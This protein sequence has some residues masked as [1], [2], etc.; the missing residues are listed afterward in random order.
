M[1]S[2]VVLTGVTGIVGSR[3]GAALVERGHRLVALARPHLGRDAHARTV[4]AL[5][6]YLSAP[7]LS[8]VETLTVDVRE[9][10][11]GLHAN[12]FRRLAGHTEAFVHCA[13]D[14]RFDPRVADAIRA[15]NV[16]GTEHALHVARALGVELFAHVSTAFVSGDYSGLAPEIPHANFG[17]RFYNAYE[18]SKYD[19]ERAVTGAGVRWSIYRPPV[20]VGDSRTGEIHAFS[21]YYGLVREIQRLRA[22]LQLG[23]PLADALGQA[24]VHLR[25][26]GTMHLPVSVPGRTN[27][28]FT[29]ATVDF[30]CDATAD[31]LLRPESAF[32]TF[33]LVPPTSRTVGWWFYETFRYLGVDGF[34]IV[35][36]D[37]FET[38]RYESAIMRRMALGLRA[39]ERYLATP[40]SFAPTA[41]TR[42]A[43][44]ITHVPIDEALLAR[45]LDYAATRNFG[46]NE[47]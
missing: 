7:Q 18:Q 25:S 28:P 37:L 10:M 17:Q 16:G 31:L 38:P 22:A 36:P 6:R 26:D 13:A 41:L 29:A 11:C 9:P 33:H 43:P 35:E 39:Y 2:T 34:E 8:N 12:V 47:G 44:E 30:V 46:L 40:T 4:A 32:Q 24:G 42:I 19:A 20:V 15:T 27:A 5:S 23:G 14:T 45:L 3:L 21:G 1:S